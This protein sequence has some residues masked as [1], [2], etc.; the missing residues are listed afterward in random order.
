MLIYF[1]HFYINICLSKNRP[2]LATLVVVVVVFFVACTYKFY[3]ISRYCLTNCLGGKWSI[4]NSNEEVLPDAQG[5]K[6]EVFLF[7]L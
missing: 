7:V 2:L 5:S 3:G 4:V 1:V 6:I